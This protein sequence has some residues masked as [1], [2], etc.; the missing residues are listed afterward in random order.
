MSSHR[1]FVEPEQVCSGRVVIRGQDA[2]HIT[3]VLRM[4]PGDSLVVLDG[5]GNAWNAEIS[6]VGPGP[7]VEAE[8]TGEWRGGREPSHRVTLYQG[9]PKGDKM[10][11]I[12]QKCTEIGVHS[13]VPVVTSRTVARL[14]QDKGAARVERWRRI[15]REA[16]AQSGR[17]IIPG[18]TGIVNIEDCALPSGAT[19]C[20][21]APSED[22]PSGATKDA[23]RFLVLWESESTAGDGLSLREALRAGLAGA[24]SPSG[25]TPAAHRGSTSILVGPEGGLSEDEVALLVSRGAVSVSLGHRILR[26]ETAGMVATALILYEYGDLG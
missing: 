22:T 18:V 4:R 20:G 3:R 13:I 1:V 15:A 14:S 12:V 9:L 5:L 24:G 8:I 26:T 25:A 6:S 7:G 2:L 10:D 16:A 11:L 19:P 17:L 21:A 23:P